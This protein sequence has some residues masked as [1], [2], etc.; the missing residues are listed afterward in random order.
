[1]NEKDFK[2]AQKLNFNKVTKE[3]MQTAE[4]CQYENKIIKMYL[5]SI[6]CTFHFT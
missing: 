2:N 3:N 4:K 6:F 1:M 5:I